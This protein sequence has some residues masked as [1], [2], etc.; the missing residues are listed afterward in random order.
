MRIGLSAAL[1]HKTPAEWAK[2]HASTGCRCVNF[3]VNY[4]QGM[5]LAKSYAAA[6]G[7]H[8]LLIA[9]VGV[10]KNPISPIDDVRKDA[11]DFAIGQ[12]ELADAI[13]ANCAVNVIGSAGERWD[14]AYK[15]NFTKETWKKAVK[16]IQTI[17]DAAAPKH[18]YYTIEPMPWM[19]PTGPDEY[20]RLIEDVARDRFAVHMDI[21]NWITTPQRYFFNEEFMEEAFEKLGK[22]IKSCHIK[23]VRLEQGFTMMYREVEC[24]GGS[25]NLEKYA[26]LAGKIDPEMPMII[27]HLH[28]EE[29]YLESIQ[30]V[31]GRLRL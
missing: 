8:G 24:G 25:I 20:L 26:E 23:D 4:R 10:W 15:D 16:S 7:E 5:D 12:L 18:T 28:S 31:K 9:E 30:Y 1:G 11:L 29:E 27:E 22:Y 6:A 3:P 19:Y 13:G 14:G 17:I 21:F 2:R